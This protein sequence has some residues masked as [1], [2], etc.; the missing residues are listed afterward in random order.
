MGHLDGKSEDTPEQSEARRREY[1]GY[2]H[3]ASRLTCI[4]HH[5]K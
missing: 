1:K 3:K 5:E 4:E 2:V